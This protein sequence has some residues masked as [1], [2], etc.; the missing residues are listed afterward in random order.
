MKLSLILALITSLNVSAVLYSQDVKLN[1]SVKDKSLIDVIRII[2]GQSNY[3]FF[4]SNNYQ[5][6]NSQVSIDV[7]DKNINEVLSNLLNSKAIT[8]RLFDNNI[9]VIT[10][11]DSKAK[12]QKLTGIVTDVL[13][14]EPLIGVNVTIEGTTIGTVTNSDGSFSIEQPKPNSTV[15]F[16][17]IG[18]NT[19]KVPYTGQGSISVKM[20]P[21]ITKLDEVVVVGY[22][23]QSKKDITGSVSTIS[24]SDMNKG[25][26]SSPAQMLQGKVPGLNITRSGDPTASP[27]I[28][29]R[30]PSTLRTGAAM[31]PFYVI[32]GVP[33]ASIDAVAADDIVSIDILRDASSTAIYG[34]RASNG[35]IMVSTK[36]AKSGQSYVNYSGYTAVEKVSNKIEML[37]APELRDYLAA[38]N[39]VPFD[40]DGS[41]TNWQKEV[42]RTGISQNHNLSF[43]GGTNKTTYGASLNYL[44]NQGIIKT[45]SLDRWTARVNLE[46]K[47]F[48][49]RVIVGLNLTNASTNKHVVRPELFANMLKYLPTVGIYKPDGTFFEN[50]QNSNYYNPVALLNN[51]FD[52]QKVI[53]QL[54]N[55]TLKINLF[56][57]LTYDA[58]V[59]LQNNEIQRN[60]YSKQASTMHL[61]ANGYSIRSEY[62]DKRTLAEN[63]VTFDKTFGKHSVKALLG[64]SWQEDK[65][66]DGFQAANSN[67]ITDDIL[68]NNLSFGSSPDKVNNVDRFG[69]ATIQ[70]LR[71]ISLY[72]R[73]NYQ[74]N[75]KYLLQATIRRDG[76]SAFG[77]NHQ[78]GT[79]PSASIGWKIINESFMESLKILS[80]LKLRFG[81][82]VSGNS[83]GFDPMISKLKYGITG[84]TYINGVQLQ[85]IG[86]TQNENPDLKWETTAMTN[87][88]LDF[89][90]LGDRITGTIEFYNKQTSDLIWYY[91]VS[92]T[93]YLYPNL[94]ANVGKVNNK[95]V[96]FLIN[97][98]PV[99]TSKFQWSTSFNISKNVNKVISLSNDQFPT[100][101]RIE[102]GV[103]GGKGQSGNPTQVIKEGEP[104]GTFFL[105]Q[106]AGRN[107]KGVSMFYKAN[108]DTSKVV[109]VADF[110]QCGN[111]QPKFMFGWNNT[112]TYRNFDFSF[113]F[114]GVYGNKI[115]NGTLAALNDV[116][117]ASNNNIPKFSLGEP[118]TDV[119]SF[120]YSNRYLEDGSYIRLDNATI[121]YTFKLN[122]T[123]LKSAR[124]YIT[125]NNLFVITKYK[126]IDPE[127]NLGGI[128]PGIDNNNFYPKTRSFMMGINVNF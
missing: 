106:F 27:S 89:G 100:F 105:R 54:A 127:I 97:A 31:E 128:E 111:A 45:S 77:S 92:T 72:S 22:G 64:Y 88:G 62:T 116:N 126:G 23:K 67:F 117:N 93:K 25:V 83:L 87:V 84:V 58:N 29:L 12:Q 114:R 66:N 98:I 71:I 9:I 56:P 110:Q 107:D 104:I 109:T 118:A 39:K 102:T 52:D 85:A 2:E 120:Y 113:F 13:S 32:D 81:Y 115:L 10:P 30:G 41:N 80:D 99:K 20:V 16:S 14:N 94:W 33:G 60:Q 91:P 1:F 4:F 49:D 75:N 28:T 108:G 79:F 96:E 55:V 3:R 6:L 69:N 47:A 73:L 82:G 53:N 19:E 18:Y 8:Y 36:R 70:T 123:K 40:D 95:G 51:E 35:V 57:W 119:N 38:V 46:Q 7:Q 74:F 90:F 101:T 124:L 59:S 121:G 61:G 112:L 42:T 5:D 125:T 21:D 34:S 122:N 65:L 26:Y 43:G 15:V 103:I 48:N 86:V 50:T 68:Y 44:D 24:A 17:Y 63:Y 37:S 11:V 76:S 78:W